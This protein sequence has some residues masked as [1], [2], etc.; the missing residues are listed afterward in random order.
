MVS[1]CL[2][3]IKND[4]IDVCAIQF[5]FYIQDIIQDSIVF[6]YEIYVEIKFYI[7]IFWILLWFI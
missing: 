1:N 6:D 7:Y 3:E 5:H 2:W 4:L